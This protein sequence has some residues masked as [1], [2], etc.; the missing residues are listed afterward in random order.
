MHGNGYPKGTAAL[1]GDPL[2]SHARHR[3][4]GPIRLMLLSANIHHHCSMAGRLSLVKA[5]KL[6]TCVAGF[7]AER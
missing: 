5:H 6:P 1:E 2:R 4:L 7:D 3:E